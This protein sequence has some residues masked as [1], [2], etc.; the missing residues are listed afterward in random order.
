MGVDLHTNSMVSIKIPISNK[1]PVSFLPTPEICKNE[2]N[3]TANNCCDLIDDTY[4]MSH[5]SRV[6]VLNISRRMI[7]AFSINVLIF[8]NSLYLHECGAF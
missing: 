6:N 4:K 5:G 3:E 8:F 7:S 1:D 2:D